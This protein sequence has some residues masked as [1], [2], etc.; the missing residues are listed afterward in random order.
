VALGSARTPV[1]GSGVWLY[2]A[3]GI[4][5]LDAVAAA[6]VAHGDPRIVAAAHRQ[7]QLLATT[8]GSPS[9][10]AI[11]LA[12]RLADTLPDP[13]DTVLFVNTA[14]EARELALQLARRATGRRT[15]LAIA[16]ADHGLALGGPVGLSGPAHTV[17]LPDRFRGPYSDTEA[18]AGYAADVARVVA[19]LAGAAT[20]P[21]AFLAQPVIGAGVHPLP[22]GYLEAAY[23]Y[24][25]AAGGLCV[26]DESTTGVGRAGTQL[27]GFEAHG[28]VPDIV[29]IGPGLGNGHPIAAI[30]T[31]RE[32]AQACGLGRPDIETFAANPVTGAIGS[33]VLDII[34]SDGLR[35][36]AADMGSYLVD[37]LTS[38]RSRFPLIGDVRGRGLTVGLDLV[39]DPGERTPAG[40]YA[41]AVRERLR[42]HSVMVGRGGADGNVLTITPPMVFSRTD[43]DLLVERLSDVLAMADILPAAT[44]TPA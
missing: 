8:A 7:M 31:S 44:T 15:V 43:V 29:T 34:E 3:N 22:A 9:L 20:P 30:V 10:P 19:D 32:L 25:R 18:S 35:H 38:L 2:D 24:V 33:V 11:E 6:H 28:V 21:A 12:Q 14:G 36:R 4:R 41:R 27:W 42:D 17:L 23:G 16:G 37:T 26:A 13:L 40:E 1:R 39:T 5:Y